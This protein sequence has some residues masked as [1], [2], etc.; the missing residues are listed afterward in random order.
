MS[1]IQ[2]LTSKYIIS[3]SND[4]IFT[5]DYGYVIDLVKTCKILFGTNK[6]P[7]TVSL[8]EL[9]SQNIVI[10]FN[11][12]YNINIDNFDKFIQKVGT[13]KNQQDNYI[14]INYYNMFNYNLENFNS[15][16]YLW[17]IGIKDYLSKKKSKNNDIIL[18]IIGDKIFNGQ[19]QDSTNKIWTILFKSTT[20]NI[21]FTFGYDDITLNNYINIKNCDYKK[22]AK[23]FIKEI[24]LSN[25]DNFIIENLTK[26]TNSKTFSELLLQSHKNKKEYTIPVS[27]LDNIIQ[28]K[29]KEDKKLYIEYFIRN[30]SKD[31]YKYINNELYLNFKGL[32]KYFLTLHEKYLISFEMKDVI[33]D[34]YTS[35]TEELIDSYKL[36]YEFNIVHF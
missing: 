25:P 20:T 32:N 12:K 30:I 26:V 3:N 4:T 5:L 6:L 27:Q 21:V 7:I 14:L 35:I 34:F 9:M 22:V 33:N 11:N 19:L 28:Y 31:C 29:S 23:R 1:I 16:L 36:L 18:N 13:L 2:S 15:D 10:E 24:L 17:W 8:L